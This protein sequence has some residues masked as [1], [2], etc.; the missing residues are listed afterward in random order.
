MLGR[1]SD[2]RASFNYFC[3]QAPFFRCKPFLH[4]ATDT[5]SRTVGAQVYFCVVDA[6]RILRGP[7]LHPFQ[8]R[9]VLVECGGDVGPGQLDDIG[10]HRCDVEGI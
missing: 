10:R 3:I 4:N 1:R 7:F 6:A 8:E 2:R 9:L 5:K